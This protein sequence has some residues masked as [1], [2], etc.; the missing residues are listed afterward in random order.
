MRT[1]QPA[2]RPHRNHGLFSDHFLNVT[3][4][5]RQDW[6]ALAGEASSQNEAQTEEGL[7]RP[8][9]RALGHDFEVQPA[10]V[11]P[12][13]TKRPDYVFYRPTASRDANKDRTLTDD[14]LVFRSET[15][16]EKYCA[17]TGNNPDAENWTCAPLDSADF[18]NLLATHGLTAVVLCED[19]TGTGGTD[20]FTVAGFLELL[21]G[22]EPV[23]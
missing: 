16:A 8:M 7:V 21:A 1:T 10:L 6:R 5:G 2:E 14:L 17:E 19:W 18:A 22:A 12:E 20:L 3:L 15:D 11:T 23:A 13:G 4:P 9:L